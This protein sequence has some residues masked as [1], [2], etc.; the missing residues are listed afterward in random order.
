MKT[1]KAVC[2]TKELVDD[3]VEAIDLSIENLRLEG[4]IKILTDEKYDALLKLESSRE[5]FKKVKNVMERKGSTTLCMM[6]S[7]IPARKG[8][9]KV[10]SESEE[11]IDISEVSEP[12]KESEEPG[13]MGYL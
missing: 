4:K 9:I 6:T 12:R 1:E 3:L 5:I 11:D 7:D 2:V 8:T 10:V 13:T